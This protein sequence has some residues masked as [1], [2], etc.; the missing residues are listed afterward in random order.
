MN[1]DNICT[2]LMEPGD[3]KTLLELCTGVITERRP[4]EAARSAAI[5]IM[6]QLVVERQRRTDNGEVIE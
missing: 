1:V 4:T 2:T 6:A 3:I 5:E